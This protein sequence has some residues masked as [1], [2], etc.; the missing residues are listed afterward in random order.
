MTAYETIGL[1]LGVLAVG[2]L[3]G[4]GIGFYAGYLQGQQD[5]KP[6]YRRSE[7]QR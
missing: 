1:I 7:I 3:L 5:G 6:R 2:V 4:A